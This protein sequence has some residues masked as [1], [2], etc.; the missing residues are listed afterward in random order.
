MPAIEKYATPGTVV[1]PGALAT[2]G[3]AQGITGPTGPPGPPGTGGVGGAATQ[4]WSE[5]PTGTIDGVNTSFTTAH[6]Y[7]TG[8]LA[9]FLNGLR[10]RRSADYNETSSTS[11]QFINA[12]LS[13]D[14][15]SVDYIQP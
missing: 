3:G 10:M 7:S 15:L 1:P 8:L 2:P 13:G 14:S 5:T 4:V 12:P 6:A 9:V 11:F